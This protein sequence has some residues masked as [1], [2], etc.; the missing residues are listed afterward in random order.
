M[1]MLVL[2]DSHSG[3]HFMRRWVSALKPDVL[4]ASISRQNRPQVPGGDSVFLPGDTVVIVT[5]GRGTIRSL[6]DIFA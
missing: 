5:S 6:E 2:S 3:L 1:K 4:I